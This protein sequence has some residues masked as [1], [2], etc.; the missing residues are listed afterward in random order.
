MWGDE[1]CALVLVHKSTRCI[2]L[3]A[4]EVIGSVV[5]IHLPMK[6]L[7]G[8][9]HK[10]RQRIKQK[11]LNLQ[12]CS[13]LNQVT[14]YSCAALCIPFGSRRLRRQSLLPWSRA[15]RWSYN[16]KTTLF[17]LPILHSTSQYY[18]IWI[19]WTTLNST[20][21]YRKD[22]TCF[23][24]SFEPSLSIRDFIPWSFVDFDNLDFDNAFSDMSRGW[25]V[26]Q[27][28][29]ADGCWIS[30]S[31]Q[32]VFKMFKCVQQIWTAPPCFLNQPRDWCFSMFFLWRSI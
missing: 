2:A 9:Q 21:N 12:Q 19:I 31:V 6:E 25:C 17:W 22:L 24:T 10:L 8:W 7:S 20:S 28:W 30:D 13:I 27:I 4:F 15:A 3:Q 11:K 23:N 26:P 1:M 16:F 14:P 32:N 29:T 18:I 5:D